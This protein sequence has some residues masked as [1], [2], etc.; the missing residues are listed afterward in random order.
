MPTL[1]EEA[2]DQAQ[3]CTVQ[4]GTLLRGEQ[5]ML[6]ELKSATAAAPEQEPGSMD[7]P[8]QKGEV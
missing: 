5:R 8:G 7:A 2:A 6:Q 1:S 4:L 3:V